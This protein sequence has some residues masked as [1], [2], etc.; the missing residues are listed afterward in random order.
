MRTLLTVVSSVALL[1]AAAPA[2]AESWQAFATASS[3]K[4]FFDRASVREEGGYV[5][6]RVRIEYSKPRESRDRKYRFKSSV[7]AQA[8]QCQARKTALTSVA[9]YLSL[10]HI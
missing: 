3:A 7:S 8:G 2:A 1:L 6:Y 4:V 9:L 5:H 10:I